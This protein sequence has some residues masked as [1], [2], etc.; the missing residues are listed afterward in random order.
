MVFAHDGQRV[1]LQPDDGGHEDDVDDIADDEVDVDEDDEDANDP[2]STL[3]RTLRSFE[4]NF[5]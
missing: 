2:R 3:I 5:T 4:W 1:R